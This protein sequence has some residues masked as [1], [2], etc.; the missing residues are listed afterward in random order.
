MKSKELRYTPPNDL[1]RLTGNSSEDRGA[2]IAEE[3]LGEPGRWPPHPEAT[4]PTVRQ[5]SSF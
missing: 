1:H 5:M 2:R 3:G 4:A